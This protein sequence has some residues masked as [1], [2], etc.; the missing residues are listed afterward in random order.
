MSV[1]NAKIPFQPGLALGSIVRG[2]TIKKM[3]KYGEVL[4]LIEK[5]QQEMRELE[6]GLA[7]VQEK[8]TVISQKKEKTAVDTHLERLYTSQVEGLNTRLRALPARLEAVTTVELPSFSNITTGLESPID[9]DITKVKT[10]SRGFDSVVFSSQYIDL[11][12]SNQ[13]MQDKIEQSS[14]SNSMSI[15]GGY[16]GFSAS[17]SFSWSSGAMKRVGEIKNQGHASKILLI[18]AMV[19]TRNV[20]FFKHRSYDVIKLQNILGA[21]RSSD[22]TEALKEKGI[23]FDGDKKCVYLLT[24]AVMGGSFSAIVTYLKEDT[25]R[26]NTDDQSQHSSFSPINVKAKGGFVKGKYSNSQQKANESHNDDLHNRGNINVSIEFIAQGAI[27]SLA[28]DSV[29]REALKYQN[30]NSRKYHSSG[31]EGSSVKDRQAQLQKA[32]YETI[33][34]VQ[35]TKVEKEEINIHSPNGVLKAYDE[36]CSEIT[37]DPS[38]GIPVG[39]NYT[40]LTQDQITT[41][42]AKA[43]ICLSSSSPTGSKASGQSEQVAQLVEPKPIAKVASGAKK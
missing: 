9:F 7:V 15:G 30:Q 40:V 37:N 32:T 13:R 17:G 36:F 29:M 5:V 28:R 21:M 23:T 8:R 33:N 38:C 1:S 41:E 16:C 34:M 12:E 6:H 18:N 43:A 4:S 31:S 42:I 20:R 22:D 24:E 14:S 19:T 11:N 3:E 25:T 10:D 2:D 39:F 26:G 35:Q 27:P